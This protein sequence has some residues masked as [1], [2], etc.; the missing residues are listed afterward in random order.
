[1]CSTDVIFYC[2]FNILKRDKSDNCFFLIYLND[3]QEFKN[4]LRGIV[5]KSTEI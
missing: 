1:M 4:L 3:A 2:Y 5:E